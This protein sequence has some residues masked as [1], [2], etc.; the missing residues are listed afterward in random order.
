MQ[1]ESNPAKARMWPQEILTLS[2][3]PIT[4][5]LTDQANLIIF[6]TWQA[7]NHRHIFRLSDSK[8]N[9]EF[10]SGQPLV[11][12]P[13]F[14]HSSHT[15]GIFQAKIYVRLEVFPQLYEMHNTAIWFC[16]YDLVHILV[17]PG[18]ENKWSPFPTI[19]NIYAKYMQDMIFI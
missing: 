7:D 6:S 5:W 4:L 15:S 13:A 16:F 14:T 17:M 11:S 12:S 3:A 1:R 19:Q 8:M 10:P 2:M 9:L 18:C